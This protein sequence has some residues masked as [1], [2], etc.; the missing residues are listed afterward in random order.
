MNRLGIVDLQLP[1]GADL[2]AW[3]DLIHRTG[4]V[5][6]AEVSTYGEYLAVP[7]DTRYGEQ[8]GL[9][10]TGQTGGTPGADMDAQLAQVRE[11]EK[12]GELTPIPRAEATVE[13][14]PSH[15]GS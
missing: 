1:Q 8:W 13:S 10:N 4:L 14:Q 11:M 9:N 6:Y 3:C 2:A 15:V 7:N 5:R 12:R